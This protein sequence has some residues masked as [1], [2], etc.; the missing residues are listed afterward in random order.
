MA[1]RDFNGKILTAVLASSIPATRAVRVEPV[2]ALR[3]A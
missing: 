2:Q 1:P 3:A